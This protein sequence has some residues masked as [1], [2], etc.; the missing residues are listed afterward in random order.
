MEDYQILCQLKVTGKGS[1]NRRVK[2]DKYPGFGELERFQQLVSRFLMLNFLKDC[3]IP[4]NNNWLWNTYC[5]CHFPVLKC[6]IL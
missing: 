6:Q 3:M 4:L 5:I 2:S 1:G